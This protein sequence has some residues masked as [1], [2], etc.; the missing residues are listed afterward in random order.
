[1]R[2]SPVSLVPRV[3][4]GLFLRASKF[5]IAEPRCRPAQIAELTRADGRAEVPGI[6]NMTSEK[7]RGHGISIR[8][9]SHG[10]QIDRKTEAHLAHWNR[11]RLRHDPSHCRAGGS[12]LA[13]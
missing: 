8:Y 10:S 4:A 1:M 13:G 3:L 7:M 11:N 2:L 6:G 9:Q 5:S 12:I